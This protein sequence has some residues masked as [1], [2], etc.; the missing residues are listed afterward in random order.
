LG[1][2]FDEL[3]INLIRQRISPIVQN[4]LSYEAVRKD[5]KLN[6]EEEAGIDAA[7]AR[8][9]QGMLERGRAL[10]VDEQGAEKLT[11]L[12]RALRREEQSQNNLLKFQQMEKEF[13]DE[14]N[15]HLK[16]SHLIRLKQIN[17]QRG[18]KY[19]VGFGGQDE[20]GL[21]TDQMQ[22]IS[23]IQSDLRRQELGP[24]PSLG[25]K[26]PDEMRA[27]ITS[28][29]ERRKELQKKEES[30]ILEVLTPEQRQKLKDLRGPPFDVSLLEAG[31]MLPARLA[32]IP[33]ANPPPEVKPKEKP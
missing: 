29:I 24:R 4:L 28:R 32:P 16:D 20:L 31:R 17:L 12:Q 7:I 21:S 30:L 2:A 8:R 6:P 5:L 26:S 22:K 19:A 15:K 13:A 25:N 10:Q 23:S 33:P 9:Q 11:A 3:D 27:E 1:R 18:V 14:L